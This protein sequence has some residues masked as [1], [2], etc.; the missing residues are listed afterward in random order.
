MCVYGLNFDKRWLWKAVPMA[1]L[2]ASL[3]GYPAGRSVA[4]D[5]RGGPPAIH[6]DRRPPHEEFRPAPPQAAPRHRGMGQPFGVRGPDSDWDRV[7]P[8]DGPQRGSSGPE[9][10]RPR[11]PSGP[12]DWPPPPDMHRGPRGPMAWNGPQF[13]PQAG[14]PGRPPRGFGGPDFDPRRGPEHHMGPP[15]GA[16][17]GDMDRPRGPRGPGTGRCLRICTAGREGRWL[18]TDRNS[19][20]KPDRRGDHLVALEAP[21]LTLVAGRSIAWARRRARRAETWIGRADQAARET[22]RCLR[23][24]TAG[25]EGRWPGTDR[26]LVQRPDR[27]SRKRNPN[28]PHAKGRKA[29][30]IVKDRRWGRKPSRNTRRSAAQ[31]ANQT[32]RARL[33]AHRPSPNSRRVVAQRANQIARARR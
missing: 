6:D 11:G 24:C 7:G 4:Q 1:A 9:M 10:D 2:A 14:P 16:P 20:R 18:G 30:A 31:K 23:I 19:V 33:W 12:R 28:C 13:G 25:R 15:P 17:G 8:P 29:S 27:R 21:V 5:D 3:V 32:A 26:S 22:G